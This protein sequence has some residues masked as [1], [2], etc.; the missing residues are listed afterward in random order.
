MSEEGHWRD[1]NHIR[2]KIL[3]KVTDHEKHLL[4]DNFLQK[5][6]LLER[7]MKV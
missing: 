1:M 7:T 4:E 3:E 6:I 5:K 2:K